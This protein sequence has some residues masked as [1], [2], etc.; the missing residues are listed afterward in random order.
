MLGKEIDAPEFKRLLEDIG[1]PSSVYEADENTI[2]EFYEHGFGMACNRTNKRFWMLSFEFATLPVKDG[3]MKPFSE[4]LHAG[5]VSTDRAADIEAKLGV[6]PK[7]FREFKTN[8]KCTG[9]YELFPYHFT[10]VFE[11]AEGVL[12]GLTVYSLASSSS[13]KP[14]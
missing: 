5:I 8:R 3:L 1:K 13:Q 14:A 9:K 11:S 2:Y 10:C 6:K 12:E 7:S 4:E